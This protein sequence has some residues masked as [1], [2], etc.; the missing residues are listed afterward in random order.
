MHRR[1]LPRLAAP[2][3]RATRV[4]LAA[5]AVALLA[6]APARAAYNFQ[7]FSNPIDPTFNQLLGINNAG[8]I[9]GY[10]G[11]GSSAHPNQGYTLNTSGPVFTPENFPGSVQTQVVA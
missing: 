1:F 2:G 9:G 3:S 5:A 6:S 10:Y 7:S 8:I 4:V 11:V